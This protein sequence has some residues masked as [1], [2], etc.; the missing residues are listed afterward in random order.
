MV[1]KTKFGLG[2]FVCI[3]N[4]EFSKIL[5]I[6]RN[7]E[8]RIKYGGD[9]GN[10]G[11]KV[12]LGETSAE[13]CLR[14][15]SEEVGLKLNQRDIRLVEVLEFPNNPYYK[16]YHAIQFVYS[17]SISEKE[18]ITINHESDSFQWFDLNNLP[19]KMLD[20]KEDIL[21]YRKLAKSLLA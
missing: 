12:E 6:K 9:W 2:V 3:F 15:A 13:A 14:E 18:K 1:E 21:R 5:L 7:E 19:D 11:G 10:I 20:T 4:R 17:A 16:E 8:K